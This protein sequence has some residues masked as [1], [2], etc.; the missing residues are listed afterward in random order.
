M[1]KRGIRVCTGTG[2][3]AAMSTCIQSPDWYEVLKHFW[4]G[5]LDIQLGSLFG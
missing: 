3:G 1:F 4:D 5:S 2:I